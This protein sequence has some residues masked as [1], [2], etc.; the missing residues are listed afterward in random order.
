MVHIVTSI[1]INGTDITV[2]TDG[3]T[4]FD[5]LS[6][7]Y[8]QNE[9]LALPDFKN[10]ECN[11]TA[12]NDENDDSTCSYASVNIQQEVCELLVILAIYECGVDDIV[13]NDGDDK[14]F[15]RTNDDDRYFEST[16]FIDMLTKLRKLYVDKYLNKPSEG[17]L[18]VSNNNQICNFMV[19]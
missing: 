19:M 11:T 5:K 17:V 6:D 2:V 8:L 7:K 18:V 13:S 9:K 12:Q 1:I 3:T 4:L 15:P 14:C 10:L 16:H